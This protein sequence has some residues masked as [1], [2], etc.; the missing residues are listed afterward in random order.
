MG[1]ERNLIYMSIPGTIGLNN[2]R[3]YQDKDKAACLSLVDSN[4]PTYFAPVERKD[5]VL[6]LDDLR[7][8]YF[9]L[10]NDK[11]E[12]VAC[13]GYAA[14]KKDKAVAVLCWG[15]VRRDLHFGGFGKQLL[16]DRLRRIVA[17]Q[18]FSTV[19]IEISQHSQG[20]FERFGFIAKEVVSDGFAQDLD[21]VRMELEVSQYEKPEL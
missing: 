5:F 7:F 8:P 17:E 6:F 10:E 15:M 21:L 2:I 11:G 12:V 4:V 9:V 18:Q 13:G 16:T 14:D 3:Q 1:I 19:M 20:F